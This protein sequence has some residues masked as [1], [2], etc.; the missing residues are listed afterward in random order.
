[1]DEKLLSALNL[2]P[3]EI[4]LYRAVIAAGGLP[5][6]QLAKASGLK[7]TTAYSVARSLIEK[8]LLTEDTTKRPRVF[9]PTTSEDVLAL[10]DKERK[11][12]TVREST[13]QNLANELSKLSAQNSYPVPT[14]RFIEESKINSFL[15]Q[16]APIWDRDMLEA[17]EHTWWGFQDHTFVEEYGDWINWY[18][19]Q[20]PEDI[21][22]KLLSNRAESE[23][24][25]AKNATLRRVIKF[26]GEANNFLSTTWAIGDYLVMINTRQKPFYLVEIHDKLMAH[27]QREVFRNLWPLV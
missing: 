9:A 27:D 21:D 15:R 20:S 2:N 3:S 11:Q 14:V 17:K 22:L 4:S 7:R 23:V 5:P 24:E 6:A 10:I 25:F 12:L 18:W 26:W 8:G 13:Y 16:Q 1:M 19:K